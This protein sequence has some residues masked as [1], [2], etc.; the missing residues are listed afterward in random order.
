M[1]HKVLPLA[2][3]VLQAV[4]AV[5]WAQDEDGGFLEEEESGKKK[6]GKA[7][8][9]DAGAVREITR[10]FYAK[11]NVGAAAYLGGYSS[12]VNP[13]TFVGLS[14]G[15]DFVDNERQ[16]MAWEVALQQGL[17]NGV[18][19]L[20]QAANGCQAIGGP[21][22]CT[23]GDLRTYTLAANYEISFYPTRR[24]GVG[25][26]AG[27][28]LLF[29]PHLVENTAWSEILTDIGADPGKQG[30]PKPVVFAGPTFEYYTK[31]SHFSVGVDV[32]VFYGI[33][34]DLGLNGSGTL[35]YT[36]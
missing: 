5:A 1:S 2:L 36:F 15:Q 19:V 29:S 23:E 17:H 14:F 34:W 3:L 33:G 9:E 30:S 31:L 16:S 13:G 8:G 35:K 18:D 11:T 25:G 28:G 4:P 32:D 21:L 24:I 6:K 22:P 20:T 7:K 27:A 26:R 10:G 12:V